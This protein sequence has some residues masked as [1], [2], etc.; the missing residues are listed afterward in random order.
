MWKFLRNLNSFSI[1][2]KNMG[3]VVRRIA[4]KW[5]GRERGEGERGGREGRERG[6]E[7][8]KEEGEGRG[9]GVRKEKEA[10]IKADSKLCKSHDH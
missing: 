8:E 3:I 6:R 7:R 9:R 5:R 2:S 4:G 10:L 1:M